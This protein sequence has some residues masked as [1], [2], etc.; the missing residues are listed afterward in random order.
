VFAIK[1]R[2]R[3]TAIFEAFNLLN[4]QNYGSYNG[5]VGLATYGRQ[6]QNTNLA[7]SARMLQFAGRFDF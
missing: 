1:E 3:L 6:V 7:Y 5:N 4:A 2:W